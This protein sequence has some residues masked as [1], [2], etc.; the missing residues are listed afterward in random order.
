MSRIYIFEVAIVLAGMSGCAPATR[1]TASA[2][3]TVERVFQAELPQSTANLHVWSA[4][5]M[6]SVVHGRFECSEADFRRFLVAS[7]LLPDRAEAGSNPLSNIRQ[8][9][10]PWWKPELLQDVSGIECHW[11]AGTDVASCTLAA[12]RVGGGGNTIVYFMVVYENKKQTSLRP[13]VSA[14]PDGGT[15]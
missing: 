1:S 3:S 9:D 15:Q 4:T 5:L 13:E 8:S 10:L 6:T 7:R 11:A 12:G 14:D 2:Q